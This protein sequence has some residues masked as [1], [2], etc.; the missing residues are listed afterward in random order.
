MNE[1]VP[2]AL[3]GAT[4][5]SCPIAP[6]LVDGTASRIGALLSLLVLAVSMS[7]G[8]VLGVLALALDFAL[9]ATGLPAFSPVA[10]V[11]AGLRALAG[12]PAHSMNAGPKRFAASVGCLFSVAVGLALLAGW[13]TTALVLGFMLG[14]CAG[15]EAFAGF[16]LAC[17][18][19][20][21]LT[22]S[23]RTR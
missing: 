6:D 22:W 17:Q 20:P 18:V 15:L 8:W 1:A 10:R 13:H 16:C 4:G 12:W 19:H 11:A 23:R 7:Q 14:T 2:P 21:W 5:P 3:N 9:R